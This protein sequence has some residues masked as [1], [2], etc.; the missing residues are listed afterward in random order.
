[1]SEPTEVLRAAGVPPVVRDEF[2]ARSV[3]YDDYGMAPV[4]LSDLGD[5][6]LGPLQLAWGFAKAMAIRVFAKRVLA[7]AIRAAAQ[8]HRHAAGFDNRRVLFVGHGERLDAACD[9]MVRGRH[10]VALGQQPSARVWSP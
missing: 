2:A 10:R 4:T 3:P 7:A 6:D 1:V 5:P 8:E 9:R